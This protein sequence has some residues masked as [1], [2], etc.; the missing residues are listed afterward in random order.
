M[1][2]RR[3]MRPRRAVFRSITQ[4]SLSPLIPSGSYT[5]PEESDSVTTLPPSCAIFCAQSSKHE[6]KIGSSS[7]TCSRDFRFR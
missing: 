5:K 3:T 4:S 7:T 1:Y 2:S 6:W